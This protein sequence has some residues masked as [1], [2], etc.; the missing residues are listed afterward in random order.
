M[1]I[2]YMKSYDAWES[3]PDEVCYI[4]E[5]NEGDPDDCYTKNDFIN[6]CGGDEIKAEIIFDLC[7]WEHPECILDEW[8]EEDEEA[9]LELK[10]KHDDC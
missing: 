5:N 3:D 9:L 7:S 2:S 4:P 1:L 8:D 6:L 10:G